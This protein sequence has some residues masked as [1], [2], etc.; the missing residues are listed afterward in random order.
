MVFGTWSLGAAAAAIGAVILVANSPLILLRRPP[1]KLH[2]LEQAWL[3]VIVSFML[4]IC[5]LIKEL[6]LWSYKDLDD[7]KMIYHK[8][9]SPKSAVSF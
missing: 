9:F 4:K 2:Q 5:D 8:R 7:Y 6:S 3:E 1:F